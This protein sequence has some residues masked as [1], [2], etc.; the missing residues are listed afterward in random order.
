MEARGR[1]RGWTGGDGELGQTLGQIR[2]ILSCNFVRSQAIYLCARLGQL[3]PG[4][5]LAAERKGLAQ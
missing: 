4:A 1:A 5:K 3:G 2:R